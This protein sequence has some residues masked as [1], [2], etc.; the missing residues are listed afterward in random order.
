MPTQDALDAIQDKIGYN[1]K[2]MKLLQRALTHS[3]TD[4]QDNY[5]RLEFLGDR[6]LG[7]VMA[8][9]LFDAFGGESE[10]GLAKRYSALVQGRTL[11]VIASMNKLGDH[12]LLSPSEREA[13]GGENEN[14]LSDVL[15]ALLGAVYL[16]GG[17][18]PA[19]AMILKLWDDNIH[20]LTDAPQ[21]PKTE[22]QEWVQ[23]RGLPLPEYNIA[24]Q[25]GP[26]HAPVFIMELRV[27]GQDPVQA[28]GPSRRQAEKSAA[29]IMLRILKENNV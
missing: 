1:F 2:D 7:L 10:G 6:V 25:S 8:H 29:R 27:Q 23:A 26:D 24:S 19:R 28:E 14:I 12:I 16:D 3:S 18:E 11:A 20:T 21:D 17:L 15:E 4:G 9:A 13:G 22:L 5:E